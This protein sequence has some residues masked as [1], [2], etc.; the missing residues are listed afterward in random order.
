MKIY[1]PYNSDWKWTSNIDNTV[2]DGIKE[3]SEQTE[4]LIITKSR[5]DRLVLNNLGYD[6]IAVNNEGTFIP[7]KVFEKL[8]NIYNQIILMY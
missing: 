2:V 6:A 1:Q 5:K 4:L 3:L 7:M 8:N